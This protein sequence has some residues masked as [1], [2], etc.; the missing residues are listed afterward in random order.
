MALPQPSLA[1]LPDG[2]RLTYI[3]LGD[4][5]G[6]PIVYNHHWLGSRLDA[7]PIGTAAALVGVRLICPDRP[8][9]GGSDPHD[10]RTLIGWAADV[11]ALTR[12]LGI[13]G[14]SVVGWSGGAPST[15][16]CAFALG[17]YVKRVGIVSGFGPLFAPG[18]AGP[19]PTTERSVIRLIRRGWLARRASMALLRRRAHDEPIPAVAPPDRHELD[20]D[21]L[22]ADQLA[23][24]RS[25]AFVQG[26][27]GPAT[28]MRLMVRPW[29][30][31]LDHISTEVL[32]WHGTEDAH[33]GVEHAL[34]YQRVLL[35]PRLKLFDGHGHLIFFTDAAE[36]LS[37]LRTG[38]PISPS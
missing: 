11:H 30:F 38:A 10:E 1:T 13:D 23:A 20:A 8:G 3:E 17:Q 33:V 36:I 4:P 9:Y 31:E 16:A 2:R 14:Y 28:D 7:I 35:N 18:V 29:G 26:V 15:I 19:L 27:S 24:S 32:M 5:D 37:A 34:E 22:L 12:T 21:P 6:F 25:N